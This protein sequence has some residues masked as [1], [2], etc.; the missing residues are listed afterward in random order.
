MFLFLNKPASYHCNPAKIEMYF[1]MHKHATAILINGEAVNALEWS[2]TEID[3]MW[4][5][6][7][8]TDFV[9]SI[10]NIELFNVTA[11]TK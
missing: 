6:F 10:K 2:D 3:R 8:S 7:G 9:G 1:Q 5:Q 11:T 4:I